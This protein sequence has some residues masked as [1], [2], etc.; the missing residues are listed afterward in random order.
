MIHEYFGVDAKILWNTVKNDL[1]EL[2]KEISKIIEIE[3]NE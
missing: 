1:P 3:E 2:D